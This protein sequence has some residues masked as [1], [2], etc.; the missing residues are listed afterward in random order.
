MS[1]VRAYELL[2]RKAEAVELVTSGAKF[3]LARVFFTGVHRLG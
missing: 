2:R 3:S 1:H